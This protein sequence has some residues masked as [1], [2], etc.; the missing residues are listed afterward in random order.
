MSGSNPIPEMKKKME[1]SVKSLHEELN[2]IHVGQ[3]NPAMIE[4]LKVDYY[5]TKTPL[6]QMANVTAPDSSLLV[7]QPYD[8]SQIESIEKAVLETDLGLNPNN[9]GD[10]VRIP[11]PKL[12]GER[13]DELVNLIQEKSEE[14]KVGLRNIRRETNK[15]ID[16]LEEDGEITEDDKYMLKDRVDETTSDMTERIDE[17]VKDKTEEVRAI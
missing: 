13:R 16:N 17:I 14:A 9:D 12:S 4:D 11:V 5:G 10:I 8:S 1:R 6:N 15:T 3:A 7:V 2:K